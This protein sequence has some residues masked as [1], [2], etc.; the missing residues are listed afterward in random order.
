MFG[1]KCKTKAVIMLHQRQVDKQSCYGTV[2]RLEEN[3]PLV[4]TT[5]PLEQETSSTSSE[6]LH[7]SKCCRKA[8]G[9]IG[10]CLVLA[11][12]AA[13]TLMMAS[14]TVMPSSND[15]DDDFHMA[16]MHALSVV[17]FLGRRFEMEQAQSIADRYR[18]TYLADRTAIVYHELNDAYDFNGNP[19]ASRRKA[20]KVL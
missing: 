19:M 11:L 2:A 16:Q 20:V 18:D 4:A 8:F 1:G 14:F 7:L 3:L 13:I 15:D 9:G 17:P 5:T 10:P 6:N 12:I